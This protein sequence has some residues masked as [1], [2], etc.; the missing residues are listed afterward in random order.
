[1]KKTALAL[2]LVSTFSHAEQFVV[3]Y[4]TFF[5]PGDHVSADKLHSYAFSTQPLKENEKILTVYTDGSLLEDAIVMN[6]IDFATFVKEVSSDGISLDEDNQSYL[7]GAKNISGWKYIYRLNGYVDKARLL[8]GGEVFFPEV[9]YLGLQ[10]DRFK[11][12]D[13]IPNKG[14]LLPSMRY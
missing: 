7:G 4:R 9:P 6:N 8:D 12:G 2:N 1:M 11:E 13:K 10:T 5:G 3:I 14:V